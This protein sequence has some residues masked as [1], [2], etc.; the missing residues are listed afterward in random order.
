LDDLKNHP[1]VENMKVEI[2][3]TGQVK[4]SNV[5]INSMK[6]FNLYG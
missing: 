5:L 4:R 1:I 2:Q 3:L 6:L